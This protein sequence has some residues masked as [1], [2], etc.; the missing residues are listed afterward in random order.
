L[1][2]LLD[3]LHH[4]PDRCALL[5][6]LLQA[7]SLFGEGRGRKGDRAQTTTMTTTEVPELFGVSVRTIHNR[8]AHRTS[9]SKG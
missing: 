8:P 6:G 4:H 2:R 9:D 7:E 3:Q 5:L 1:R